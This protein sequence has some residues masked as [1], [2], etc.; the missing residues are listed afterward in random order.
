MPEPERD[1]A[2]FNQTD[3]YVALMDVVRNRMTNRRN[4]VEQ[5]ETNAKPSPSMSSSRKPGFW[6]LRK[7]LG[8]IPIIP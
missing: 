3:R 8:H 7:W 5:S 6:S 1:T 4:L 2:R